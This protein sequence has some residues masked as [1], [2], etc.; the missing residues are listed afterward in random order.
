MFDSS[1]TTRTLVSYTRPFCQSGLWA[2]CATPEGL[3]QGRQ[4][5][6]PGQSQV[7]GLIIRARNL[8]S[9]GVAVLGRR[10]TIPLVITASVVVGGTA[11]ALLGVPVLSGASTNP[12]TNALSA[13]GPA[14]GVHR[15]G[16]SALLDAAAKAL[17]LTTDELRNRLSDGKTTIDRKSTRLNS[18]HRCISYAV[19]CLK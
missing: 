5:L 1:S 17:N 8:P 4:R 3:S 16:A 12:T 19:F 9:T 15:E 11:G 2:S 14:P 7:G 10:F 18:S 13:S 6:S